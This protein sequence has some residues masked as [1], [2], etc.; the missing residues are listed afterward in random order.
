[1]ARINIVNADNKIDATPQ[2]AYFKL[3]QTGG[4]KGEKG[5]TGAQGP[6]GATGP[7]GA[8][9]SVVVNST[10]T[11]PAGSSATVE[12]IGTPQNVKLNF[13]IPTGPQGPQGE[14]GPQGAQGPQG[15]KGDTG[16]KGADGASAKVTVG[17]TNTGAAGTNASVEN[18]GSE[19]FAVLNFTIPRGDKGETGPMPEIAQTTG[20]ATDEVMSQKATTD[21]LATKQN[22][23]TA[24]TGITIAS[25][26][27]SAD[28]TVLATK[29]DLN[30]Y[31][32]QATTY[33][34]TETDALLAPKL[35]ADVVT[36]LPETGEEGKLYLTPKAYTRQ[37]ATGNPIAAT[38][39]DGA[40]TL[41]SFQL[42]GDTEQQTYT[43]KNLFDKDNANIFNGYVSWDGKF[44][45]TSSDRM[46]YIP[47]QPSTTYTVQK[48]VPTV[49]PRL[50]V[51]T[52]S[53]I[54]AAGGTATVLTSDSTQSLG[55]AT[56][57]TPANA[58]YL[59]AFIWTSSSNM[60]L[61]EV[62]NGTQI[63]LGST[64]TAYEP[65]VG[66]I[67]APNPDYPQA[68]QTVTGE[69]TVKVIGKNLF[70]KNNVVRGIPQ[71][72]DGSIGQ[73]TGNGRTCEFIPVLPDT[74]Y[75]HSG[76][77]AGWAVIAWYKADKSFIERISDVTTATSPSEAAYASVSCAESNLGTC[78]FEI[79]QPTTY[80]PYHATTYPIKL[81]SKNLF[82]KNSPAYIFRGYLGTNSCRYN[83]TS[84]AAVIPVVAGETY[85]FSRPNATSQASDSSYA[86]LN[87]MPAEGVTYNGERTAVG[88][89][90]TFTAT[91]PAG[92]KYLIYYFSWNASDST[93]DTVMS[94][95]QFEE[96]ST[97]TSYEQ[98]WKIELCKLGTYQD[99]IWKDG[100]NW[101][102]HKA[103]AAYTL[104]GTE[105]WSETST[106]VPYTTAI[107]DYALSG[108]T[109][110]SEYFIGATNR[111]QAATLPNNS[112]GF[113]DTNSAIRLWV[114]YLDKWSTGA[115]VATWLAQN[116]A[117]IYY[118]L[119]SASQT[120]TTITDQTL[121]AQ[122]EA[123][124]TAAL[125]N[126]TNTITNS[127]AGSNLAGD[128]EI[129]YYGYNPTN[130][131]DKFIWLDLNN[132]YEQIGE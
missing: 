111:A 16:A 71:A 33:T 42:D 114:K 118:A 54:P 126:G 105:S 24:G 52:S 2:R 8:S 12:N 94:G 97:A 116:P 74:Q 64:A 76:H 102:V 1:M 10:T 117:T 35:E 106:G 73:A 15:L 6:Q 68:V 109:P 119:K 19:T 80:A 45:S 130:R 61:D 3:K 63:E 13:G 98:F 65:Y 11:L 69:Q 34:K 83:G 127:A 60:A 82:D 17:N 96:G 89:D 9:A 92:A 112:I 95:Y 104:N 103:T 88:A 75:T 36:S 30:D 93:A 47:C 40:G 25:D 124:R 101:K 129:T 120:D 14:Q 49:Q 46:I 44:N 85:T 123:I 29:A 50:R 55:T 4:P 56:I 121:I 5:D 87:S 72:T 57:T 70:D 132:N 22:N 31:A 125:E 21:A 43:G 23:L 18:T 62:L 32:P 7:Q 90:L 59:C 107:T 67:P 27:V 113:N 84:W 41:E 131:Y 53:A 77:P 79:G 66:G 128:M 122:L 28:T 39:S 20:Q 37:T 58:A 38:I 108:N 48:P 86:F 99:Y 115:S 78:Q 51:A 110:V 26:T 100:D 91:A 81:A